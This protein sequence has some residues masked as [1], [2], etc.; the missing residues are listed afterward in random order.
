[1]SKTLSQHRVQLATRLGFGTEQG[2]QIVQGPMLDSILQQSQGEILAEFGSQLTG[3][4]VPANDFTGPNDEP[5]VPDLTLFLRAIVLARAHYRQ[6]N[7]QDE[8]AWINHE[9]AIRGFVA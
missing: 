2:A 9:S 6:P 3:N 5:S 4:T 1:M 8:K 7:E